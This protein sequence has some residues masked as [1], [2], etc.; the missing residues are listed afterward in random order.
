MRL[1][2]CDDFKHGQDSI[3]DF[4][5]DK[6]LMGQGIVVC[7]EYVYTVLDQYD[8][9]LISLNSISNFYTT[10]YTMYAHISKGNTYFKRIFYIYLCACTCIH[11]C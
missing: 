3:S 11:G 2:V 10:Q 5:Y 7:N 1:L 9:I 4:K 8:Y 6:G